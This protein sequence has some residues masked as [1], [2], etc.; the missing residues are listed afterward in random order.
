MAAATGQQ[1]DPSVHSGHGLN[2]NP[3]PFSTLTAS[4]PDSQVSRAIEIDSIIDANVEPNQSPASSRTMSN[5]RHAPDSRRESPASSR[6]ISQGVEINS[7]IDASMEPNQSPTS[8]RTMSNGGDTPDNRCESPASSRTMSNDSDAPD[9]CR[10][11]YTSTIQSLG[12]DQRIVPT[13]LCRVYG[14]RRRRELMDEDVSRQGI[15]DRHRWDRWRMMDKATR[16]NIVAFYEDGDSDCEW[17]EFEE[18]REQRKGGI[19]ILDLIRT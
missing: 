6:T 13:V 3:V 7:I 4:L 18:L 8:S 10:G 15:H 16:P 11:P 9:N 1:T 19:W 17:E 12:V 5:G 2:D 14:Q